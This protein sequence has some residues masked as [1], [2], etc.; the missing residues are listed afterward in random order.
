MPWSWPSSSLNSILCTSYRL[1]GVSFHSFSC[2]PKLEWLVTIQQAAFPQGAF[3]NSINCRRTTASW[4]KRSSSTNNNSGGPASN[5]D[6]SIC[7]QDL[8]GFEEVSKTSSQINVRNRFSS[9]D[10]SSR[11]YFPGPGSQQGRNSGGAVAEVS[12][13]QNARSEEHT[14]E[15]QSR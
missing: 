15:L 12:R 4:L 3:R 13:D 6:L 10:S 9:G 5:H 8:S 2:V 14:S 7:G 11:G 1:N